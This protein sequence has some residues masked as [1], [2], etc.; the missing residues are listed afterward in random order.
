M[1]QTALG[2]GQAVTLVL[3]PGETE[4]HLFDEA[5]TPDETKQR[6]AVERA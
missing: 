4:A 1:R 2:R 3:L 5:G 6:V